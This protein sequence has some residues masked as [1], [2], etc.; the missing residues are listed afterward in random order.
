MYEIYLTIF[1][2]F[3]IKFIFKKHL[4]PCILFFNFW[5]NKI[6]KEGS[7]IFMKHEKKKITSM[8]DVFMLPKIEQLKY[9]IAEEIGVLDKVFEQGWGALSSKESGKIGGLLAKKNKTHKSI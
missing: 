7:V 1:F 2:Y 6:K 3:I 4:L 9:E 5:N 8:D